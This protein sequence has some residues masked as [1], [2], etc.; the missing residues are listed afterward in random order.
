MWGCGHL[1]LVGGLWRGVHEGGEGGLGLEVL[2]RRGQPLLRRD[3]IHQQLRI[4]S[5]VKRL[6]SG[7]TG[8]GREWRC[9]GGESGMV[10]VGRGGSGEGNGE[11]RGGSGGGEG[12]GKGGG[13]SG[14]ERMGRGGEVEWEEE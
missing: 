13:R 5:A 6:T 8:E 1:A 14:G 4:V 10:G 11:R 2:Q 3:G 7:R 12:V 9:E